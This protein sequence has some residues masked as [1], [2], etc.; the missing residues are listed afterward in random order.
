MRGFGGDLEGRIGE[1]RRDVA[2]DHRRA[3]RWETGLDAALAPARMSRE[4]EGE[5]EGEG[6]RG[7]GRREGGRGEG[8]R[9]EGGKGGKRVQQSAD[10]L[11]KEL[12]EFLQRR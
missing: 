3:D 1:R 9:R 5:G 10:D 6:R 8:G 2:Y 7:A 12:D 11:D 4:R